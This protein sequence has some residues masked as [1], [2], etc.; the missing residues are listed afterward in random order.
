M[1]IPPFVEKPDINRPIYEKMMK[2]FIDI[3]DKFLDNSQSSSTVFNKKSDFSVLSMGMTNDYS[4]A[5][6]EGATMV[7]IGTALFGTR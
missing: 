3:G 2:L 6:K 4:V 5:I 1:C 7:R